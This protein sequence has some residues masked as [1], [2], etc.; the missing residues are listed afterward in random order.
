MQPWQTGRL[1]ELLG[2][3]PNASVESINIKSAFRTL[4]KL[5][6]HD[7]NNSSD[8]T[9]PFQ[10]LNTA[11]QILTSLQDELDRDN[12]INDSDSDGSI[13]TALPNVTL[14]T[15]ENSFSVTIDIIDIMFLVFMEECELH[16]NVRP[17]DRGPNGIQYRFDYTSPD[18]DEN[19]GSLSLTF[20]ATISRLLVQ[21]TSYLLCVD[22]HLPAIYKRAESRYTE[23]LGTW[24][25]LTRRRGIG[26]RRNVR[27]TRQTSLRQAQAPISDAA[28]THDGQVTSLRTR[29]LRMAPAS[30][31]PHTNL[32]SPLSINSSVPTTQMSPQ[33][34]PYHHPL[35]SVVTIYPR[36][37]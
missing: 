1:Y 5:Y 3:Q 12:G 28:C 35:N 4:A 33:V 15:R 26:L 32:R 34:I 23:D 24:R 17:I 7:K 27:T 18:I 6:Y 19:Y 36:F 30:S 13:I 20:Y 2:L 21:G 25:S 9:K 14:L 37:H 16:H 31:M 29:C 22:E 10:K 11:C 8:A